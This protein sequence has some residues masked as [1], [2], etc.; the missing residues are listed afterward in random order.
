MACGG[1]APCHRVG[2][3][4]T[5]GGDFAHDASG[6]EWGDLPF[7]KGPISRVVAM[8]YS[9]HI[10]SA[11]PPPGPPDGVR[12]CFLER[13]AS[14]PFLSTLSPPE[15]SHSWWCRRSCF[16]LTVVRGAQPCGGWCSSAIARLQGFSS[17]SP[18]AVPRQWPSRRMTTSLVVGRSKPGCGFPPSFSFK[19][20]HHPRWSGGRA[21]SGPC[22]LCGLVT[23]FFL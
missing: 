23:H 19:D 10:P 9:S 11:L 20:V 8:P 3:L 2:T 4:E 12:W 15:S 18:V 5:I 13:F 7:K 16:L 14:G 1:L 21:K 22:P 17:C 6:R